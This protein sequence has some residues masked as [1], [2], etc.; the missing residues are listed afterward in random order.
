MNYYPIGTVVT[1]KDGDRPI[2]IYGRKQ[3]QEDTN[4]IWDYVACLYPE[5]NLCDDYNIFFQH[6]EIEKVYH[7]GLESEMED[8]MLEVLNS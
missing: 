8:R 6:E 3:I 4:Y 1:L 2:M 7:T 5:G